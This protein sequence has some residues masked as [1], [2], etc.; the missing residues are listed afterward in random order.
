MWLL[1]PWTIKH[2]LHFFEKAN[3]TSHTVSEII[4]EKKNSTHSTFIRAKA[5][6]TTEYQS[7]SCAHIPSFIFSFSYLF[8]DTVF[9]ATDSVYSLWLSHN[10]TEAESLYYGVSTLERYQHSWVSDFLLF[11]FI[12]FLFSFLRNTISLTW[13]SWGIF[14]QQVVGQFIDQLHCWDT[15]RF[16][17]RRGRDIP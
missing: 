5:V 11:Y 4:T 7:I 13:G 15:I 2:S 9:S 16:L 14:G 6:M 3:S 8:L 17:P 12:L 10:E 1:T